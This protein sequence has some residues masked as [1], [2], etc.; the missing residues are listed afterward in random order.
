M[1]QH[2]TD[3]TEGKECSECGIMFE[4]THYY[5]V[6]CDTCYNEYLRDEDEPPHPRAKHV[7]L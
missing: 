1:G 7:E 2:A 5:P 4:R 6:L 3:K